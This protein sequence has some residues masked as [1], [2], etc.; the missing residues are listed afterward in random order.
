[1]K[2]KDGQIKRAAEKDAKG[3]GSAISLH[4]RGQSLDKLRAV[5]SAVE[6]YA[7]SLSIHTVYPAR[8]K[9][10]RF[11]LGTL[12]GAGAL[13][14]GW[15]LL[16]P[17]QRLSTGKPLATSTGEIALNGWLKLGRDN[18]VVVV[19]PK[20]EM[21]QGVHT[22]L[23][24][25]LA[26]ELDAAWSQVRI[27]HA[28]IDKIYNNLASL[29]DGLPFHPDDDGAVKQFAGWMTAKT[30]REIGPM[31]TGGS[32]SIKD[33]WLPMRQAGASARAMLVGAAAQAWS[34]PVADIQ[35]AEGVLT[36]ANGKPGARRATFGEL[37][38]GA[39]KLPLIENAPLKTPAQWKFIGK[40]MPRI[41]AAAKGRGKASDGAVGYALDVLPTGLLYASVVMCPTLGGKVA[42]VDSAAA[43]KMAGVSKVVSLAGWHGGT[44]GVAVIANNPWRAMQAVKALDVTWDEAVPAAGFSSAEAMRQMTQGLDNEGGFAYFKT[45]DVDAALKT[46]AKTLRADYS[47]PYLAHAT[48]EP[49]NCTVQ[50]KDGRATVWAPTQVPERA[51]AA[52]AGVLSIDAL[53]VD[54][55]VQF[56]GGGFGRRLCA[57][58]NDV[59]SRRRHA[60]RLLS[61]GHRVALPGRL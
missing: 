37:A 27:E 34:V 31:M 44:G 38:E 2:S 29:V 58:A 11:V 12:A 18:S 8:M 13:V 28:P 60:A 21:G 53:A 55:Q 3:K 6:G 14:I 52:V 61:A 54:M 22:G 57:R 15:S 56:L 32:S 19:M 10:R 36:H 48:L 9:T 33:L 39:A 24:M 50:F 46:A 16:P 43:A 23:A 59:D 25:L 51:R 40:P 26:D 49:Q 47:A 20:S 35:I 5:V 30:M 41:E 17:R 4:P 1:L 45:G 7:A 42:K